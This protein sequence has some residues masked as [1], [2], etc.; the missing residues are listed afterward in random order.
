M[1][2]L[3]D[4]GYVYIAQPPLYKIKR[5]KSERYL[6][7]DA[8]LDAYLEQFS[9]DE[10]TVKTKSGTA[11]DKDSLMEI[12]HTYQATSKEIDRMSKQF[13][14]RFLHVL[15]EI[16]TLQHDELNQIEHLTLWNE[17]LTKA[18]KDLPLI[19]GEAQLSSELVVDED[20]HWHIEIR[21]YL[22]GVTTK[23]LVPKETFHS[24]S[25]TKICDYAS[26]IQDLTKQS[27]IVQKGQ[28]EEKVLP[29]ITA[30]LDWII[31]DASRGM[32]IKRFKGLGE[33]NADQLWE[34]TMD[35]RNRFML[36]VSLD[37]AIEADQVFSTLMG[38]QVEPRKRFIEDNALS[39]ENIDI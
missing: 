3:I 24:K 37:D 32:V 13:P 31:K 15:T 20:K 28:R 33:M 10:V 6:K 11:I 1:P 34:T 18:L 38:D 12:F 26:L 23:I 21:H 29:S 22:H 30:V 35:P 25:Y 7:D 16:P 14:N 39:A 27:M 17:K 4:N 9:L 2:E 36:Q 5:G 8:A 19:T